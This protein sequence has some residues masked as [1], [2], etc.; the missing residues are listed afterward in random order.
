[1]KYIDKYFKE[2][3]K[4]ISFIEIKEDS[5]VFLN[6]KVIEAGISLPLIT[7]DLIDKIHTRDIDEIKIQSIIDGIIYTLGV[8]PSFVYR[9]EYKDILKSYDENIVEYI[10]YRAIK[11]FDEE[12]YIKSG[13]YSRA[14]LSLDSENKRGL[15]NYSLVLEKL[16]IDFVEKKDME[17]AEEF[18]SYAADILNRILKIDD[19]FAL[20]Y[21]KL[22]FHYKHMENFLKANLIWKKFLQISD[23]EILN[24]EVRE[25]LMI[26]ED[27]SNLEMG[28]THLNFKD[29]DKALA[30]FGKLMPK[31]KDNWNINYLI[32]QSYNGLQDFDQALKY[33]DIAL[34]IN[35]EEIDI[36]NS[37][38]SI[39]INIG[40]VNKAIDIFTMGIDKF[41]EDYSL[42]FNRGI[43]FMGIDNYKKAIEDLEIAHKLKADDDNIASVLKQLKAH[44][45]QRYEDL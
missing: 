25:E 37:I 38:G 15:F 18:I 10:L 13:I 17:K 44:V 4:D 29:F 7:K 28:I 14:L 31:Y 30:A 41:K 1:M 45:N 24:Q 8:D 35:Q 34:D 33:M 26:I 39:L 21:Y 43:S 19:N 12:D 27:D 42:Y 36:Y 9:E 40:D 6:D 22:G 5:Q 23:N 3:N 11:I 16:G 32:G 2:K 20:A